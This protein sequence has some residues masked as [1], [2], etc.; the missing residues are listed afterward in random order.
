MASIGTLS[1]SIVANTEQLVKGMAGAA[2]SVAKFGAKI[3]AFGVGAATA[4]A[5]GLAVLA[6]HSMES[7]DKMAKLADRLG[8]STEALQTYQHAAELA[9]VSSEDVGKMLMKM[10]KSIPKG[11]NVEKSF[12]NLA[13]EISAI[14]DPVERMRDAMAAFG[15]NGGKDINMLG[16]NFKEL[17]KEMQ[18]SGQLVSRFDA[19][20]IE[21]A[22]V[23]MKKLH[24]NTKVLGD[25]LAI[26]VAPYVTAA[27]NAYIEWGAAGGGAASKV[28]AGFELVKEAM[29][30]VAD[31]INLLKVAFNLFGVVGNA[32]LSGLEKG[33]QHFGNAAMGGARYVNRAAYEYGLIDDKDIGRSEKNLN[34]MSKDWNKSMDKTFEGTWQVIEKQF[35]EMLK[36]A[37]DFHSGKAGTDLQ[38]LFEKIDADTAANAKKQADEAAARLKKQGEH[39]ATL[40]DITDKKFDFDAYKPQER[41]WRNMG[42]FKQ[43]EASLITG[44]SLGG[45][46]RQEVSSPSIE[47]KLDMMIAEQSETNQTLKNGVEVE[48]GD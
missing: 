43:I 5:G 8:L 22:N 16:M 21:E 13:A 33:L 20:K 47:K 12:E 34:S 19:A 3:A 40:S 1:V 23:A 27:V 17:R 38:A 15:R 29:V 28:K 48:Y 26:A 45:S 42:E 10:L 11:S 30:A 31:G 25:Q 18:A 41:E 7:I 4:A 44:S 46:R 39:V 35:D 14:Q 37:K 36:G 6:E 24:H 9:G 32:V 2:S